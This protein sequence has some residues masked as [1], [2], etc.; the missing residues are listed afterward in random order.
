MKSYVHAL[1]N[2]D[3]ADDLE[4]PLTIVETTTMS[5]YCVAF[6][7]SSQQVIAETSTFGMWVEH[8]KYK[9]KLSLK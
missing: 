5:T 7:T 2:G 3:I 1:S 4:W 8:S 9:P 6:Y